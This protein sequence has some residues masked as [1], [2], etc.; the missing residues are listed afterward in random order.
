MALEQVQTVTPVLVHRDPIET[1]GSRCPLDACSSS[2]QKMVFNLNSWMVF[3]YGSPVSWKTKKHVTVACSSAEA[4]YRSMVAVTCELK[5]LKSLLN[6]LGIS[7]PTEMTLFC[8]SQSTLHLAHNPMFHERTKHI[9]VDY[10][11]LRD[12]IIDGTICTSYVPTTYRLANI[13]TK[14]LRKRQFDFLLGKL[15][16]RD[17][18]TP[19]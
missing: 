15:D 7:H 13:F 8:N 17:L 12:D 2:A 10:H 18:H 6:N 19:T 16:I 1:L 5:L 14:A 3:L 11:F 9:E 4:E